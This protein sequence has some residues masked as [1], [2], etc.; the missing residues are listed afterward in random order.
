MSDRS[1][2][3]PEE[4][5]AD[6]A[7]ARAQNADKPDRGH[8]WV[9]S[10]FYSFGGNAHWICQLCGVFRRYDDSNRPCVGRVPVRL[11]TKEER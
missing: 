3:T 1:T 2:M 5:F 8:H 10:N 11:R 4:L 7:R 6:Y 9:T